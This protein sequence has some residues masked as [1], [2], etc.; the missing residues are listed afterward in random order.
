MKLPFSFS[1]KFVFRLLF[2]GFVVTLALFPALRTLCDSLLANIQSEYIIMLS[3]IMIGW[4]FI[5]LDMHIYMALEGRR[6]WPGWLR[7]LFQLAEE[8]RLSRLHANYEKV[9]LTDQVKYAEISVE[10]RR[11]PLNNDGEPIAT[12]PTRL[13]NLLTAYEEYPLRVYGMDSVFYWYRI[14]LAVSEDLR[15][16]IDSQQAIADSSIYMTA[17]LF[18]AGLIVIIYAVQQQMPFA[19]VHHLPET[20]LLLFIGFM[21]FVLSYLIY[22]MSLHLHASFGEL[23]KS[24]FDMHRGKVSVD[25]IV[26]QIATLTKDKNIKD[27]SSSEKYMATWRYLHNYKIKT[28]QG[29]VSAAKLSN[30]D[31]AE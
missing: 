7:E 21:S 26:D 11:F 31:Q 1:L 6:Y 13:G 17:A 14:W 16:H 30:D 3:T 22:R 20:Q 2:P 23:Y 28:E 9:K 24:M 19:W 5:V 15:E 10:L 12:F 4:L 29:V 27:S 8:R 25:E 18:V